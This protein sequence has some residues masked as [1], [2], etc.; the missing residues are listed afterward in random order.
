[1]AY[2]HTAQNI[3]TN[4][5]EHIKNC[6]QTTLTHHMAHIHTT[7]NHHQYNYTNTRQ[8]RH[9]R[10]DKTLHTRLHTTHQTTKRCTCLQS[11]TKPLISA[12]ASCHPF[13]Q[14]V[15]T[16]L[17][18]PRQ[19]KHLAH[20]QIQCLFRGELYPLADYPDELGH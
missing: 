20:K 15:P 16:V 13:R 9:N 11:P 1:M 6:T 12:Y 4:H 10:P 18:R 19:W 5:T 17:Y 3:L 14:I 2:S 8:H 7:H